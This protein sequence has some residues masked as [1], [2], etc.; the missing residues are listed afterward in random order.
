VFSA[1]ASLTD[2]LKE[3][4]ALY[5]K[6][7]TNVTITPN[8]ASSGTLQ[9]QIEQGAPADVFIAA[10]ASQMDAL[11]KEDLIATETRKNLLNNT[12]VLVS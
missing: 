5:I 8:F 11:A 7:N 9:K 1:A 4:N 12:L 6:T 2:A 3:L 10:A